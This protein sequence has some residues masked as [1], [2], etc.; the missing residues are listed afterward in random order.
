ML[1]TA[2]SKKLFRDL[3]KGDQVV[4]DEVRETVESVCYGPGL[5]SYDTKTSKPVLVTFVSGK[6]LSHHPRN[7]ISVLA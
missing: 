1:K 5:V 7:S 4:V 2:A 6:T 3:K